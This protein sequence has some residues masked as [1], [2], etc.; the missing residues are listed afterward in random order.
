MPSSDAARLKEHGIRPTAQR[1]AIAGSVL[2]T[3]S[4]PSADE[5]WE[6]DFA[7][8]SLAAAELLGQKGIRL[9]GTDAPSVDPVTTTTM[10]A[11]RVLFAGNV[12]ILEAVQLREVPPGEYELIALPLKMAIDGSPV[13]AVLR[14]AQ[15]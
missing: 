3:D 11:H 12:A 5:V 10:A 14:S 6:D 8:L 13:R 9:F 4:H 2:Y 7:Y 15:S 1:L